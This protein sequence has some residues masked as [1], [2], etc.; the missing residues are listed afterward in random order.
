[1]LEKKHLLVY[2]IWIR[3]FFFSLFYILGN[4]GIYI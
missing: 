3:V 1:M 2:T 4:Q